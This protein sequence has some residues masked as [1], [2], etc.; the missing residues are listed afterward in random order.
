MCCLL[1]V[2]LTRLIFVGGCLMVYCVLCLRFSLLDFLLVRVWLACLFC[3]FPVYSLLEWW[4][5]V[6]FVMLFCECWFVF[7]V[8]WLR[9]VWLFCFHLF[10]W[11]FVCIC[12]A[13]WSILFALLSWVNC[14]GLVYVWISCV[15]LCLIVEICGLL[16]WDCVI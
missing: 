9:F 1:V 5:F 10:W 3:W 2:W 12:F 6:W 13:A 16:Y 11:L 14:L 4:C 8:V 15:L 7:C